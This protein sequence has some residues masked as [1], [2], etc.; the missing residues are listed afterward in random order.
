[1]LT[2]EVG[3]AT[4]A[5]A[6][7]ASFASPCVVPL[8]PT[9]VA[10]ITGLGAS[11]EDPTLPRAR[12]VSIFN[13][14]LFIAGFSLVFVALGMTAT[15]LGASL[16]HHQALLARLSGF[17][18]VLFA[19]YLVGTLV[20][21]RPAYYSE[22]RFQ[23]RLQ[24]L[25]RSAPLVAGAAFAFGWTPCVGPVLGSVLAIAATQHQAWRGGSL[26]L[27]YSMGIGLPLLVASFALDRLR[28]VLVWMRTHAT[29]I[30]VASAVVLGV[31][32]VLLAL[33]RL[34]WLTVQFQRV[35]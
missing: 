31:V 24:S 20:F 32:G 10:V 19:A 14:S 34:S 1:M 25:G 9:Y 4:A 29:L 33:D 13:T 12:S 22:F 21:S 17:A 23:P 2:P 35:G 26:L 8:V 5:L 3:Y 18:M 7:L 16:N 30:T 6:G 28:P 11:K 27:A 15:S